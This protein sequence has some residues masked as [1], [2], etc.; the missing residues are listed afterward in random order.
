MSKVTVAIPTYNRKEQLRETIESVLTQTFQD[1][2]II[3][4]DNRSDYD[5]RAFV[6][7]FNDARISVIVSDTNDGTYNRIFVHRFNSP[8]VI[9]FH[10]DDVMHPELLAREVAVLD[11][12][13][14][15]VWIGTDLRFVHD[16]AR[17]H[18]FDAVI[19]KKAFIYDAAGITRLILGGF[20]LCYGS[21]MYRSKHLT[22][23]QMREL[24]FKWGDRPY[25]IELL[26]Q[27]KAGILKER[28]VNYRIH[29][30]QD[31]QASTQDTAQYAI[32]LL[33]FYKDAL[34]GLR[35]ASDRRLFYS[36]VVNTVV[37]AA[38]AS[39]HTVAEFRRFIA[40]YRERD[41]LYVR[42]FNARGIFR[43]LRVIARRIGKK[44]A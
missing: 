24:Y 43:S 26:K 18:D 3:V 1:F 19:N 39:S 4:F 20:N 28:L 40:P 37:P 13:P 16:D 33:L 27:G 23:M 7:E 10:D 21:V 41:L 35:T 22:E 38:I 17:M 5:V 8:Y 44:I 31:S 32:N 42:Y 9:I 15:L 30:G 11:A 14:D 2:L 29:P 25:L 34:H 6:D 36:H 12:H